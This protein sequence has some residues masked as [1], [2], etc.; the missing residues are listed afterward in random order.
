MRR[1]LVT[2]LQGFTGKYVRDA[3]VDAGYDVCNGIG[4]GPSTATDVGDA[5]ALDIT[6]LEQCRRAIDRLRPTHIVHLAAISFVAHDDALDMYRVNVL[7][8]LNLLQ[9]CSDVGHQ[10]ERVLI[11]SS[12]N[13]YGNA[14]GVVDESAVPAPVNHYAAS[15]LAME[16]MVRTWF[17]QIPIVITRPFNYTGRGQSEHFLVSKIVSHF[18]RKEA[19]LELGNLDVARDFSDVRTI[20]QIY[21]ALL[22][23]DAAPGETVNVCSERPFTLRHVVQL[24]REASRHDLEIS[25]NPEFV[26]QNE[27]KVLVGSAEKLR[28]LVPG[29]EPIDFRDTIRWMLEA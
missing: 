11:A 10:P 8:T 16:H 25:V 7:G 18:A 26:R 28:R 21:R 29:V 1:A 6:S 22:E 3:L 15:K 9:A 20:A 23:S 27:I 2:G 12:A 19:R 24:V 5:G 17:D 4:S 14:A 13:V